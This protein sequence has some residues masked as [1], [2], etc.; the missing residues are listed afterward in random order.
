[1]PH[2]KRNVAIIG[3][4][5][6][7]GEEMLSIL[8]E[9][10]FPVEKLFLYASKNSAGEY[11]RFQ[12]K[13][14]PVKILNEET[15]DDFDV[16]DI[17]LL[18]AGTDVSLTIIPKLASRG[19]VSIDNSNAWRMDPEVPLVVPEVN[20]EDLV[21]YSHKNIVANPN[22]ST[23][24]MVQVLKPI[25][26]AFRIKRVVVATYQST[27]GKGKK[28]MEELSSQ[29]IALLN[30]SEVQVHQFPH[31]IAFNCIP[32]IDRFLENGYTLEEM[33]M[34]LETKKILHDP[35]IK[36]TATCVRV[37]VFGS[38]AEAVNIETERKASAQEVRE[39]LSQTKGVKM[40]DDPSQNLYPL[41]SVTTGTDDTCVGR[42]REDVSISNGI[43]LWIV[44]D[45]LRKGAALNAVQIAE[46][47][48][49]EFL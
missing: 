24:Q 48:A 22:C 13:N 3:A 45:N 43:N 31:Q 2:L 6:A 19:T 27:S 14:V 16:I 39:L 10:Q 18:S 44:S 38:H 26:D 28:A 1:M 25:H 9:R 37:P 7:V 29:T 17:A 15:L 30:Q 49:S 46:A 5:G 41:N 40:I 21:H 32:H 23:V 42:I 35:A 34:V 47:L 33:K 36:V 8:E 20:Y 12:N 11:K 4:T